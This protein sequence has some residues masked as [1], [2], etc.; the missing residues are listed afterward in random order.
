MSF[1]GDD[2]PLTVA[3]RITEALTRSFVVDGAALRASA[4]IGV[5]IAEPGTL[6]SDEPLHQAD[7][8]NYRA[9]RES[10]EL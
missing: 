6:T 5:A 8:A 4:S 9:E 3:R 2:S 10:Q 1:R 7:V